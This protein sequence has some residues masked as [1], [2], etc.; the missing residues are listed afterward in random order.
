MTFFLNKKK[1]KL[2]QKKKI[3]FFHNQ[4]NSENENKYK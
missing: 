1:K 4:E 3:N 2:P